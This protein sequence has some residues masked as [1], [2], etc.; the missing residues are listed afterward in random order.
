MSSNPTNQPQ[1]PQPSNDD[2]RQSLT[3]S[4]RPMGS[5]SNEDPPNEP[6]NEKP[7]GR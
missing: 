7:T 3:E 4:R 6:P 2:S 1:P 5:G